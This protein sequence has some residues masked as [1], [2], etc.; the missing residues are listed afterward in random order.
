VVGLVGHRRR[1]LAGYLPAYT[2][3]KEFWTFDGDTVR[4]PVS[5][6]SRPAERCG[7]GLS[8]YSAIGSAG[9]SRSSPD[10]S[11]SRAA[12]IASSATQLSRAAR[13]FAGLGAGISIG[14]RR[15]LTA[16]MLPPL[17]AGISAEERLLRT[18]FGPEYDAAYRSRTARLLPG[19]Y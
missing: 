12:S 5:F 1:L 2:D 10:T 9:W 14:G 8:S 13:Q 11:W 19:L 6:F 7:F 17:L 3:R 16:L 18:Q 15:L 4:W